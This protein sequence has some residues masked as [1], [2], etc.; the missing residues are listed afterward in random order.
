MI[1]KRMRRVVTTLVIM[2]GKIVILSG[3]MVADDEG[4]YLR[5]RKHIK[6]NKVTKEIMVGEE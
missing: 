6:N 4:G 1:G 3:G 2:R 5:W